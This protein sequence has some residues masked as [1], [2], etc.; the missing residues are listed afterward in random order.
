[1][2]LRLSTVHENSRLHLSPL[3]SASTRLFS[4]QR[5]ICFS[6]R[7]AGAMK[8]ARSW[9]SAEFLLGRSAGVSPAVGRVFGTLRFFMSRQAVRVREEAKPCATR[10][11]LK[12]AKWSETNAS[13][14]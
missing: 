11:R 7:P 9:G 10:Y 3:F 6:S 4:W 2:S 5:G 12:E 8:G 13:W 1:M 14:H